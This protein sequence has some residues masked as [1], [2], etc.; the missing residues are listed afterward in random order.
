MPEAAARSEKHDIGTKKIVRIEFEANATGSYWG[1]QDFAS[2]E[3]S[4]EAFV[5]LMT[6]EAFPEAIESTRDK[7]LV[8]RRWA[9]A[10]A[11]PVIFR[12][13]G[14][15]IIDAASADD[16]LTITFPDLD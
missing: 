15:T 9:L 10:D 12:A 5:A 8:D 16:D 1:L 14:C 11:L 13:L 7:P 4:D 3:M 2:P 6:S